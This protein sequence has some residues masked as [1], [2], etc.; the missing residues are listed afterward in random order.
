VRFEPGARRIWTSFLA[1]QDISAEM[2]PT[3][4]WAGTHHEFFCS[5]Y[6]RWMKGPVDPYWE[7]HAPSLMVAQAGDVVLMDTRV[8]HAG[9][10]NASGEARMLLHFSFMTPP[11]AAEYHAP[12]GFTNNLAPEL[13]ERPVTIATL[14]DEAAR[15][16]AREWGDGRTAD[17]DEPRVRR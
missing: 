15:E 13:R 6:K 5:F 1:L 9:G 10:A 17:G 16:L 12:V 3:H 4:I 11:S 14:A 7:A 8:T 2:G